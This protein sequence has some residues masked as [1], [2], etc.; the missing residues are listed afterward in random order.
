VLEVLLEGVD[1]RRLVVTGAWVVQVPSPEMGMLSDANGKSLINI[2]CADWRDQKDVWA[3]AKQI[4]Y[5]SKCMAQDCEQS[6]ESGDSTPGCRFLD[7]D[8]HCY[9][10]SSAQL[11]CA[12]NPSYQDCHDGGPKWGT[13]PIGTASTPEETKVGRDLIQRLLAP[14]AHARMP[15]AGMYVS[16]VQSVLC[17]VLLMLSPQNTVETP[18]GYSGLRIPG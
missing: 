2:R 3:K 14:E 15:G 13:P 17:A 18:A 10:Q 5:Y 12:K 4:E 6:L 7:A 16:C 11:W 8:N 9:A 1:L